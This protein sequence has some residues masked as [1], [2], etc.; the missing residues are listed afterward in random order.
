MSARSPTSLDPLPAERLPGEV[1]PLVDALNGL[2]GRL[3]DAFALQRRFA[4]DAAHELRTPLTAL[5]LQIQLAERAQTEADRVA[6][7]AKL[8]EGVKRAT[9]LV[10]QLLATARLEPEAAETPFAPVA[11]DVARAIGRRRARAGGGCEA[12]RARRWTASSRS[13]VA[14][15]EEA[16]R[17]LLTNLVDNALRY[18]TVGGRVEVR[19]SAA[20]RWRCWRSPT[21]V[22]AS[23]RRSAC[24]YS[25]VSIA[26]RAP[27]CREAASVSRSPAGRRPAPRPVELADGLD[28][29]GVTARVLFQAS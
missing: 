26:S 11:L 22:R 6:T 23:P 10:Q 8:K 5:A 25:I 24:G 9:R 18:T 19:T 20:A 1:R 13:T 28:G 21:T 7:L 3:G 17:L 14:G 12:G 16:L 4:A 2:L 29:C 27:M 15:N